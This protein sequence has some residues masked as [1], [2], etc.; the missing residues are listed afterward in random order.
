MPATRVVAQDGACVKDWRRSG[1]VDSPVWYVVPSAIGARLFRKQGRNG[2]HL[3]LVPWAR[4]QG[5]DLKMLR[6][7]DTL[8]AEDVPPSTHPLG[9]EILHIARDGPRAILCTLRVPFDLALFSGHF[10]TVPIVPGAVLVGWAA[11]LAA[12]HGNWVHGVAVSHSMKFRRIVQPGPDY[13]LRL[14]WAEDGRRLDFRLE[15][16]AALHALGTLLAPPS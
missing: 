6:V 4:S 7:V 16:D 3:A 5:V 1:L 2:L 15:S 8:P 14:A 13:R 10:P 11:T 12:A 9:P